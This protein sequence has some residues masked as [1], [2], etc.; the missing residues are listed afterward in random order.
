MKTDGRGPPLLSADCGFTFSF[1]SSAGGA[2]YPKGKGTE[3]VG[4]S[5]FCT[6]LAELLVLSTG[7]SSFLS[8]HLSQPPQGRACPCRWC[9]YLSSSTCAWEGQLSPVTQVICTPYSP[10]QLC[11]TRADTLISICLTAVSLSQLVLNSE[12]GNKE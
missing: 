6:G 12:Q 8:V 3:C 1:L 11:H 9:L 7:L 2:T 4:L 5:L 10:A